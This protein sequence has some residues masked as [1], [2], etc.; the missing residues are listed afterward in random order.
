MATKH[1][2]SI[3]LSEFDWDRLSDFFNIPSLKPVH[4]HFP[5]V[6]NPKYIVYVHETSYIPA[7]VKPIDVPM[8]DTYEGSAQLVFFLNSNYQMLSSLQINVEKPPTFRNLKNPM[9][10]NT[11]ENSVHAYR[12][13]QNTLQ[14]LF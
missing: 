1:G 8:T 6:S 5:R 10:F 2:T 14:S 9:V 12:S 7:F 13:A 3:T 11:E 4:V